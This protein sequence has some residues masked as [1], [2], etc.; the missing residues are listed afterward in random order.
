MAVELPAVPGSYLLWLELAAPTELMVGRLGRF[1]LPAGHYGYCGSACGPGG[2]AARVGRHLRGGGARHW[3]VDHLRAAAPV[4]EVWWSLG[5]VPDEHQFAAALASGRGVAV[6]VPRFGA[7]DCR[8]P[9]HLYHSARRP[10]L[11]AFRRRLA[12]AGAAPAR[13][14]RYLPLE[15]PT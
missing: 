2:L 8:C 3:H 9:S 11:A 14:H 12:A 10:S 13:L 5:A 15:K 7:S 4:R 1:R 6:G